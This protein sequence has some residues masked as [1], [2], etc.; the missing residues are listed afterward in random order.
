MLFRSSQ[1]Y[2]LRPQSISTLAHALNI[3]PNLVEALDLCAAICLSDEEYEKAQEYLDKALSVNPSSLST[4]SLQAASY[5]MQGR[6]TAY[7]EECKKVLTVNPGYGELYHILAQMLLAK[8]QFSESA[9][10]GRRAIEVDPFLWHAYIELGMNLMR[11]GET[12]E[13]EK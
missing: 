9:R 12:E 1:R 8:R 4:R 2:E 11:I 5:R 13:A 6:K 10:L 3:N 7:E